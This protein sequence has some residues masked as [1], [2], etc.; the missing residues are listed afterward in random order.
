MK[1]IILISAAV[2]VVVFSGIGSW[3][4]L[5]PSEADRKFEKCKNKVLNRLKS[6]STTVFG[7]YQKTKRKKEKFH[8]GSEY[9]FER[10]YFDA[11]AQNSFGVPLRSHW[12]CTINYKNNKIDWVSVEKK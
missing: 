8:D 10:F 9:D 7:E 6:P 2:A 3:F 12:E 5:K 1:K 11:D 4:L